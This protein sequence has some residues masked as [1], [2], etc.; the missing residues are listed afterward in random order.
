MIKFLKTINY[1]DILL[2]PINDKYQ[3]YKIIFEI[4]VEYG[5]FNAKMFFFLPTDYPI[6]YVLHVWVR[7]ILLSSFSK[8]RQQK[9]KRVRD[10]LKINT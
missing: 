10:F 3:I 2:T 7:R 4:F 1:I 9:M 8:C 5:T 6:S